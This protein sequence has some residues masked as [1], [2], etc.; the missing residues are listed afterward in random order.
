MLNFGLSGR[1]VVVT[2]G[3]SGIGK[4]VAIAAARDGAAVALID[5]NQ[6]LIDACLKE[7]RCIN[8]KVA[9]IVADVSDETTLNMAAAKIEAEMGAVHGV[10]ACAGTSAASPAEL[11]RTSDWRRVMDV[12]ALGVFLTCKAFSLG[13]IERRSGAIVAIGSVDG[14]G[15]HAGR[16]AYCASKFA[17]NGIVQSL[18]IEWGRHNVRV[19]CVAPTMVDTPLVRRGIPPYFLDVVTD[20]TP[21]GRIASPE[22]IALSVLMLLSDAA[23]YINGVVLPVDGG[24]TAGY[25]TRRSGADLSSKSLL[26]AGHYQE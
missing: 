19:N 12:N 7:I 16:I 26:E 2:G 23:A 15:A 9:G 21:M 13:M 22:D 25:F 11:Y 24:L 6:E 10:V 14:I 5:T 3:A 8:S 20:R 4:A 1:V 17:V 18:A